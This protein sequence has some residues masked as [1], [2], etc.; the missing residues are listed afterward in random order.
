MASNPPDLRRHACGQPSA[1]WQ[2]T[3]RTASWRHGARRGTYRVVYRFD[4]DS[5][6]VHVLDIDHHS[7]I[8]H[9]PQ[10]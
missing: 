4:E 7:E 3:V 10:Q 1:G 6:I 5:R 9:R 2:A 8:Y